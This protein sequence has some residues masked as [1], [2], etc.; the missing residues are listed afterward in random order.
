[1]TDGGME[2][3]SPGVEGAAHP[4]PV[5]KVGQEMSLLAGQHCQWK[6]GME[7]HLP[8]PQ[9]CLPSVSPQVVPHPSKIHRDALIPL[10]K[11]CLSLLDVKQVF[12]LHCFVPLFLMLAGTS[13]NSTP[14]NLFCTPAAGEGKNCSSALLFI[15]S[16]SGNASHPQQPHFGDGKSRIQ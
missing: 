4:A 9:P 11:L 1:M 3:T 15:I 8:L 6:G 10:E 14:C 13:T 16:P 5:T 7:G 2:G 12:S